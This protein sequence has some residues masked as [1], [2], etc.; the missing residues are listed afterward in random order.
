M[1]L[2]CAVAHIWGFFGINVIHGEGYNRAIN[3]SLA[4][5]FHNHVVSGRERK[6]E[7][8]NKKRPHLD[9]A[10]SNWAPEF[11]TPQVIAT[12]PGW[13]GPHKLHVAT[14]KMTH[15]SLDDFELIVLTISNK[16][17]IDDLWAQHHLGF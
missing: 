11:G 6:R 8:K 14:I 5:V 16:L 4:L 7:I 13:V 9:N 3:I 17:N 15:Q 2:D 12:P 1:E 10:A